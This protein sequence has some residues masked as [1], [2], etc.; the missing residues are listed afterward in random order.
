MALSTIRA[1]RVTAN[2]AKLA[3]DLTKGRGKQGGDWRHLGCIGDL[4]H[5]PGQLWP[6]SPAHRNRTRLNIGNRLLRASN[7]AGNPAAFQAG[8]PSEESNGRAQACGAARYGT[9]VIW[10][11]L[12]CLNPNLQ[13]ARMSTRRKDA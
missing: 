9:R 2:P 11:K 3:L 1:S 7:M 10:L 5:R 8:C 13:Q 12:D 4:G 6:P